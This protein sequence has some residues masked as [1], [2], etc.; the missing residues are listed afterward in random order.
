LDFPSAGKQETDYGYL[1]RA[2][3][4][5]A[6]SADPP[7]YSLSPEVPTVGDFIAVSPMALPTPT[8]R[9]HG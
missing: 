3:E 8:T 4:I 1:L 2:H 7:P 6:L 9:G 5:S